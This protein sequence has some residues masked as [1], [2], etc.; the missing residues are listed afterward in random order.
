[1]HSQHRSQRALTGLFSRIDITI[2]NISRNAVTPNS[3]HGMWQQF[4]H[5]FAKTLT[6]KCKL[7]LEKQKTT[8]QLNAT[9]NWTKCP[10]C[11][12]NP[13]AEVL[14]RL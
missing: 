2:Q 14:Q 9:K 13:L 7:V 12:C 3:E 4:A 6:H 8:R 10:L 11:V 1:M 5:P